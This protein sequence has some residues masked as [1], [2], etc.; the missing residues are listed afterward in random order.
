VST[1]FNIYSNFFKMVGA[2]AA[3]S[4][5]S[6]C[7]PIRVVGPNYSAPETKTAS[8]WQAPKPHN[9]SKTVLAQ[10]WQ[11]FD[12][13]VLIQLIEQA[14]IENAT[15]AQ[16]QSRIQQ[17]RGQ[18][19]TANAASQPNLD[20]GTSFN[21]AAVSFGGPVIVRSL[22][23]VQ[24]QSAW[25]ID[26]FGGNRREREAAAARLDARQADWH[27]ARV[28][29]ATETANL[30]MQ[31]RFC[32]L[33]VALLEEDLKS[34]RETARLTDLSAKAGF[35][36]PANAA[37]IQA[38][39][40]DASARLIA[41]QAE[42]DLSV[43][44]LVALSGLDES[45]LRA[46][47][48]RAKAKP[49]KLTEFEIAEVP[50]NLLS[51]R[52]DLASAER[53][54]A[55]ASADIGIAEAARYPRLSLSG[56]IAPVL[57]ASAGQTVKALTW[58]IGPA[59]NLPLFDG[60]RRLANVNTA[61]ASYQSAEFGYRQKVRQA[62]REVEDALIR[63]GSANQRKADVNAAANGYRTNLSAAQSRFGAGVGSVLE[64][65]ESRR[66]ALVAEANVIAI[67]RD[68]ITAWISL[69]RA[70]GGGW[71]ASSPVQP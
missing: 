69:Y 21:R 29:V 51:Q 22:T 14:Q 70:M 9:G 33:Q 24:A 11:Q 57:L 39:A 17:A 41:Q 68:R 59:L 42:C 46:E 23:Q 31:L 62:V 36:A 50:A 8:A 15:V 66:L 27:D 52:P 25:E 19:V 13:P 58:S 43:K 20:V 48:N 30:Y 6:A 53:E 40:S 12:D 16:A 35:Q 65:E 5:V 2:V 37:L 54:L 63:L 71:T 45:G 49:P 44:A 18:V 47:L 34:R 64:L 28:A 56:S 26:L 10:W 38:S 4:L 67:Q 1:D 32:E 7:A 60:G 61:K 55:A 3:A